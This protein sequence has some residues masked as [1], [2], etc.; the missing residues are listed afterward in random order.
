MLRSWGEAPD[1]GAS[2]RGGAADHQ[3]GHR[4]LA[5][6][7]QHALP[8]VVDVARERA[9]A[10]DR[11]RLAQ[12]GPPVAA[13]VDP[14]GEP[15]HA[16]AVDHE[17]RLVAGLHAVALRGRR[18]LGRE[19]VARAGRRLERVVGPHPPD[20]GRR[21]HHQ[22]GAQPAELGADRVQLGRALAVQPVAQE[23]E[24]ARGA[25]PAFEAGRREIGAGAAR[26]RHG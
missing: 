22:L 1:S 8:G 18:D 14:V 3:A 24:H 7:E 5:P 15:H 26:D 16:A 6:G 20:P 9:A 12:P 25:G 2:E 23:R 17:H 11:E 10:G 19:R 4:P 21:R 13:R